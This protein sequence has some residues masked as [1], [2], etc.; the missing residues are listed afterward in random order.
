[1]KLLQQAIAIL[2]LFVMGIILTAAI[3]GAGQLS[4]KCANKASH[5][6]TYTLEIENTGDINAG[7]NSD[8]K[9]FV[10]SK[11]LIDLL[12]NDE[13]C[14]VVLHENAHIALKH[15]IIENTKK[16]YAQEYAADLKAA[17]DLQSIGINGI[18]ACKALEKI[19][20]VIG[21]RGD[22]FSHPSTANRCNHL[23]RNGFR[24]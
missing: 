15:K 8:L 10:I 3:C 13:L 22:G 21:V 16:E 19:E 2:C 6:T 12:N 17:R 5:L 20:T 4:I 18:V 23:I 1:M 7:V 11:G 14:A 9:V 24:R